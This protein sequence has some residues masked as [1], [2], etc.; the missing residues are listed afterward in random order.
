MTAQNALN[1]NTELGERVCSHCVVLEHTFFAWVGEQWVDCIRLI[2]PLY[3]RINVAP[4]TIC[5]LRTPTFRVCMIA[6]DLPEI[7]RR[8]CNTMQ[9]DLFWQKFAKY[10]CW[11][12]R[13]WM[14][15]IVLS[16]SFRFYSVPL[17]FPSCVPFP[18]TLKSLEL[19]LLRFSA[20]LSG[21]WHGRNQRLCVRNSQFSFVILFVDLTL[22][23]ACV[24]RCAYFLFLR[25]AS[26]LR[27][28]WYDANWNN[29]KQFRYALHMD[30]SECVVCVCLFTIS[31]LANWTMNYSW[32]TSTLLNMRNKK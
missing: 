25:N 29:M 22:S 28:L 20:M 15:W 30:E 27:C 4:P 10:L 5:A 6:N 19:W 23:L 17:S 24:C 32:R 12:N 7:K 9:I 14:V 3:V 31:T 1:W 8:Q 21:L 2:L 16:W 13:M 18:V 11:N 26:I